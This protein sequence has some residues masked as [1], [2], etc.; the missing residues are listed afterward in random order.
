[1]TFQ[2]APSDNSVSLKSLELDG[3]VSLTIVNVYQNG[4][5]IVTDMFA[6]STQGDKWPQEDLI[7]FDELISGLSSSSEV[8]SETVRFEVIF[9]LEIIKL[10]FSS[11]Q[12]LDQ[13][14]EV[15]PQNQ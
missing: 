12:K 6:G 10:E 4:E 15:E 14:Q 8:S 1:M 7:P 13:D 2:W 5:P 3:E 11:V 9:P